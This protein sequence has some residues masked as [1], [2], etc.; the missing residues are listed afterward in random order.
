MVRLVSG[1]AFVLLAFFS[2]STSAQACDDGRLGRD[3]DWCL[4][5]NGKNAG[6]ET[7]HTSIIRGACLKLASDLD[8][9]FEGCQKDSDIQ[10]NYHSCSPGQR[11]DSGRAALV[12]NKAFGG[13]YPREKCGL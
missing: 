4:V 2:T 9:G 3:L 12:R 11:I 6:G 7:S 1:W 8:S 13:S 5:E 10:G